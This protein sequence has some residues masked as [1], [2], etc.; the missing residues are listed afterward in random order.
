MFSLVLIDDVGLAGGFCV[1]L[2]KEKRSWLSGR[3]LDSR[4]DM[5]ELMRRKD[6]ILEK[7]L[8]KLKID[9]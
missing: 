3:Y 5:D 2:T 7:D 9:C 1:W 8:L 6:E 4:W